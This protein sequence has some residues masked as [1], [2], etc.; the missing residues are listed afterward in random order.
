MQGFLYSI[1]E[2]LRVLHLT[3]VMA[4]MAGLM[5]L[6][7]LFINH[8]QA[9]L[10]GEA[11]KFF[12]AMERR[13]LKGIMTPSMIATW[14]FG[15]LLLVAKPAYVSSGW[16]LVKILFVLG[17]TGIHGFYS[18]A[19]KKFAAGEKPRTEKFWRIINEAPFLFLIIILI[20]V[21]VKP[22]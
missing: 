4:W 16:F 2:W 8:H 6:P 15:I 20:M 11:A 19:T 22:F 14:I 18:V 1:E 9:T 21:L 7:R 3:A 5:Y 10:D 12:T 13:L 17:I